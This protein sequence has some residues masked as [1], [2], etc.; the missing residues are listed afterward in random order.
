MLG[1]VEVRVEVDREGLAPQIVVQ[2]VDGGEGID[3]GVVDDDVGAAEALLDGP[4]DAP[5]VGV[6]CD[7]R[8]EGEGRIPDRRSRFGRIIEV[9]QHDFGSALGE[10]ECYRTSDAAARARYNR[11]PV[12]MALHL[13]APS[14]SSARTA[15]PM[16]PAGQRNMVLEPGYLVRA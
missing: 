11:N 3:A 8:G 6:A 10:L 15:H 2:I 5:P 7:V 13:P 14:K 9:G 4:G 16:Q 1:A 12:S